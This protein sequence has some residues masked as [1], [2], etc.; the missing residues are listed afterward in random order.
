MTTK[1]FESNLTDEQNIDEIHAIKNTVHQE[2][3]NRRAYF[4][5]LAF[6]AQFIQRLPEKLRQPFLDKL[7]AFNVIDHPS[8]K[9][10]LNIKQVSLP[11]LAEYRSE[12][13]ALDAVQSVAIKIHQLDNHHVLD[14]KFEVDVTE[15]LLP[16]LMAEVDDYIATIREDGTVAFKY[17][18]LNTG[19]EMYFNQENFPYL[20]GLSMD[21]D[22]LPY[23]IT[24]LTNIKL[25]KEQI[26]A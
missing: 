13:T 3:Y 21:N 24:L 14:E 20:N 4:A 17:L 6:M 9:N 23:A 22:T 16:I 7:E 18:K 10:L 1:Y 25:T 19:F 11:L 12:N 8:D 2:L 15:S 26:A 5:L